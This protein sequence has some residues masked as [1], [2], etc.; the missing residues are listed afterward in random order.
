[1]TMVAKNY[2]V[3]F[4]L[5]Y[6]VGYMKRRR[7]KTALFKTIFATVDDSGGKVEL[8][9]ATF[10]LEASPDINVKMK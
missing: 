7:M 10:E 3:E 1:M 2:W 8:A 6:V 5:R 9:S 4:T